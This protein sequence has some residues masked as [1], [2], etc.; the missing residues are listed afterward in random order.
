MHNHNAERLVL[1]TAVAL[2]AAAHAEIVFTDVTE[3]AGLGGVVFLPAEG[4]PGQWMPTTAGGGAVGDFNN[5]GWQDLFVIMG[6]LE[7]DKLF[8]NNG[9]GTFTDRAAEWGV[10]L[11][12]KGMGAAVGDYNNDGWL[13]I[14]ATSYGEPGG[15]PV[16]TRHILYQNQN[17]ESFANVAKAT[18]VNQF[19]P[20]PNGTSAAFGDFDPD[21]DLDLL[22][23]AWITP[24]EGNR[25]FRNDGDGT[26]TD[27][28]FEAGLGDW[29]SIDGFAP[30]FA[31]TNGDRYPEI[32]AIG[33]GGTTQY[34][35]NNTDGTFTNFTEQGG[36][37]LDQFGMG[38]T[39]GD[40]NND[41]LIDWYV[42]SI[43]S[44]DFGNNG[45]G[46]KLYLN[47]GEHQ[48]EEVAA[49]AGVDDGGW[50][51][52]NVSFDIDHDGLLDIIE[53]NGFFT[54]QFMNE[55]AKVFHSQGDGTFVEIAEQSGFDHTG[56]GRGVVNFDYDNDGDQ[57]V[58]VFSNSDA[59]QLFRNDTTDAGAWLRVFLDT[60]NNSALAPNGFGA[61]IVAVVGDTS[62]TRWI[63]GHSNYLS[64]S[65]LSAHFGLGEASVVDSL[66]VIWP[67]GTSTILT[68]VPVNQHLTIE[69]PGSASADLNGDGVVDGADLGLLLGA[70]GSSGGPAD[71][72]G[73]GVVDGADLG[74]LLG[75]WG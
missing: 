50:G 3:Q 31:D 14:Y 55:R 16:P 27:V 62:Y 24:S 71:L 49:E 63:T 73:D 74:V 22:T 51:W 1:V 35:I 13:D 37:G 6:G 7:P 57:D 67:D 8:I 33:D 40:F 32:F 42:S 59:L 61:K 4:Y 18:G 26:F 75:G 46:Q 15:P 72:N 28:T 34:F 19:S 53:V 39:L 23:A 17:G 64:V 41:G 25:L 70:W 29:I 21:G 48:F 69:A 60:S 12:H 54:K 56:Q 5:D 10:T 47:Q 58:A 43:F 9:D 11:P 30:G 68:D 38:Q 36:L 20:E 66:R 65:E 2:A 44:L 45:E 52:G